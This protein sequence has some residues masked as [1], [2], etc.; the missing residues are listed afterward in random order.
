MELVK[1]GR[2]QP[3]PKSIQDV[4]GRTQRTLALCQVGLSDVLEG[5]T[6]ARQLVGISTVAVQGRAVTNVLQ[7]LRTFDR[8]GFDAWYTPYEQQMR[9]DQLLSYFYKLRTLLLKEG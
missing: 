4:I 2:I 6:L 3:D 1:V 8:P 9:Q 7:H 5:A